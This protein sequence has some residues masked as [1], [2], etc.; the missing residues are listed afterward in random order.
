MTSTPLLPA[1]RPA[2]LIASLL[3]AAA[4]PSQAAAQASRS[5]TQAQ[6]PPAKPA[7]PGAVTLAE[8]PLVIQ[9]IGLRINIP[10]GARYET[11][12]MTGANAAF[13]MFSPGNTWRMTLHDQTSSDVGL[14]VEAVADH[15]V[16]SIQGARE[17]RDARTNTRVGSLN[18]VLH[19]TSDLTINGQPA[20]RFYVEVPGAA[21]GQALVSGY[22]VFKVSPGRFAILQMDCIP[23]EYENARAAY[24]TVVATAEFR[25]PADLAAERALGV[26]ASQDLLQQEYDI[27]RLRSFLPDVQ[28][29][30]IYNPA[31]GGN[32]NDATERAYQRIEMKIGRRGELDPSKSEAR[33]NASDRQEGLIVRVTGRVLEGDRTIDTDSVFF[34]TFDRAEEAW[35]VRMVIR[36]G[37]ESAGW[38]ET[39]VRKGDEIEV[40]IDAPTQPK[41]AKEW[42]KPAEAYLSQLGAYM[43]PRMLAA[44]AAPGVF[45]FYRYQSQEASITLRRDVLELIDE[46]NGAW[47]LRTRQD[48]NAAE[49]ITILDRDGRIIRRQLA[50]G[51]VMEPIDLEALKT[52]WRSKGLPL[53]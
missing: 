11:T 6:N 29:F 23:P 44:R 48:E 27:E 25:D 33:Y 17:Q 45:N 47:R 26:K 3:I 7:D 22:T 49:D 30:R 20:A 13:T 28:W 50:A 14:G 36:R 9:S 51:A 39:G 19:R 43:L 24:E 38:V 8:T 40:V 1:L 42:R 18:R 53:N 16:N 52:L 46:S 41:A 37:K 5:S 15:L 31:P 35:T 10:V 12:R 32:R 21:G 34:E 4:L 2:L